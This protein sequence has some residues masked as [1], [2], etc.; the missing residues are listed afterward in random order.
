[1]LLGDVAAERAGT[2]KEA[3]CGQRGR[4]PGREAAPGVGS[5]RKCL[6]LP[7]QGSPEDPA[8]WGG[9][10]LAG[11]GGLPLS[12]KLST[13]LQACQSWQ[14]ENSGFLFWTGQVGS[15]P[16]GSQEEVNQQF[17]P[18][19]ISA[20]FIHATHTTTYLLCARDQDRLQEKR[21]CRV[22]TGEGPG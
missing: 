1:M 4:P 19:E 15:T 10:G 7:P 13:C 11:W 20:S 3:G 12:E 18:G 8:G 16:R 21:Q 22:T 5:G 9:E 17:S 6:Q 14:L 2:D